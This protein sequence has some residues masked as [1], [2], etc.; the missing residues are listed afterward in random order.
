MLLE[1]FINLPDLTTVLGAPALAT[2]FVCGV[3][4]FEEVITT[5]DFF[6]GEFDWRYEL[7]TE[8]PLIVKPFSKRL[9][10]DF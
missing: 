5:S 9:R 10:D 3:L 6:Y 1:A 7:G 2:F 4:R 8:V